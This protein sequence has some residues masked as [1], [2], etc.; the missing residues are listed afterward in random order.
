MVRA[1]GDGGG[2]CGRM[3]PGVAENLGM[4]WRGGTVEASA[5]C[6]NHKMGGGAVEADLFVG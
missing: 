3:R 2:R 4:G 1:F 5:G 6:V